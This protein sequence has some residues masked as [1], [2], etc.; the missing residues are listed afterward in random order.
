MKRTRY[1]F[2][3]PSP[4]SGGPPI[5]GIHPPYLAAVSSTLRTRNAVVIWNPL[6]MD[7]EQSKWQEGG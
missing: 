7:V 4:Q 1:E 3:S 5:V 2:P 6:N